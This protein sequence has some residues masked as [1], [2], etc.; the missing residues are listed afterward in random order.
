MSIQG[1]ISKVI[2]AVGVAAKFAHDKFYQQR[3][4]E[5]SEARRVQANERAQDLRRNKEIQRKI[6][7]N[8][9]RDYLSKQ[10]TSLGGT[11]G[12]LPKN[13]QKQIASQYTPAQ[14]KK[15]MDEVDRASQESKKHG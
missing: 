11:I 1:S 9:M 7:R 6:R 3:P 10:P 5:R 2:G 13:M 15:L 12:D 4:H 14:R 8:F